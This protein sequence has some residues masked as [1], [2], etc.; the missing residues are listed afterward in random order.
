MSA[1]TIQGLM[2]SLPERNLTTRMLDAVDEN[3][4]VNAADCVRVRHSR[5]ARSAFEVREPVPVDDA[6][7]AQGRSRKHRLLRCELGAGRPPDRARRGSLRTHRHGPLDR[8]AGWNA[9]ETPPWRS[10]ATEGIHP[11]WF[12]DGRTIGFGWTGRSPHPWGRL[13]A[14]RPDGSGYHVLLGPRAGWHD[15]ELTFP[16]WSRDGRRLAYVRIDHRSG[17]ARRTIE[18]ADA[19]GKQRRV[20]A[21]L[22]YNPVSQ[23]V[24]SWSPNGNRIAFWGVCGSGS[25]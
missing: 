3:P 4:L 5:P 2:D 6:D 12:P 24:P 14:I 10:G 13:A 1:N 25:A 7:C 18:V 23:G 17:R 11:A 22:P 8:E 16:A 19:G 21:R 15:D 20:L 9:P